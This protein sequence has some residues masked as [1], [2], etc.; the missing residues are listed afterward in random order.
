MSFETDKGVEGEVVVPL[1]VHYECHMFMVKPI[2]MAS[3]ETVS[4]S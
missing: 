4:S 1:P 3:T 2:V